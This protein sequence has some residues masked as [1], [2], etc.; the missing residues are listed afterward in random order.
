MCSLK[1][2]WKNEK[3]QIIDLEKKKNGEVKFQWKIECKK[4]T[5]SNFVIRDVIAKPV[6]YKI[7]KWCRWNQLTR[8]KNG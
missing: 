3:I 7:L 4:K 8:M 1:Y 5:K 6:V 2:Q